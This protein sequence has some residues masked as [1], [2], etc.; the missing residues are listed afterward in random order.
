MHIFGQSQFGLNGTNI[1]INN[2]NLNS[3]NQKRTVTT[4]KNGV[5]SAYAVTGVTDG[6][7]D[8]AEKQVTEDTIKEVKEKATGNTPIDGVYSWNQLT[9]QKASSTGTIYGIYDLS[10]GAWERTARICSKW[11]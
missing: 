8:G 10:G 1:A 5:D 4:G 11:E 7:E 3:G 2:I 9:G 6:T